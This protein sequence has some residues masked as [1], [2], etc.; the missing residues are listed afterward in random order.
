MTINFENLEKL[1]VDKKVADANIYLKNIIVNLDTL[2]YSQN[3]VLCLIKE[4]RKQNKEMHEKIEENLSKTDKSGIEFPKNQVKILDNNIDISFLINKN[5][6]D[7]IQYS[8]N[9]LDSLAQLVNCALIY[10]SKPINKVDFGYL[11]TRDINGNIRSKLGIST[12]V[13]VEKE[14][15]AIYENNIFN[16]LRK[17]NNRIKHIIDIETEISLSLLDKR[18]IENIKGFTKKNEHFDGAKLVDKCEE[19]Y[20]F[21]E[22][23]VNKV[24]MAISVDLQN[25]SIRYRYNC[26]DIKGQG[27]DLN[28]LDFLI[29][30]VKIE[31][32]ANET[33]P[34]QIE[35]MFA[36]FSK[37]DNEL[38]LFRYDYD[39]ILLEINGQFKGYA[40]LDNSSN[41]DDILNYAKYNVIEDDGAK[42][43]ELLLNHTRMR[44]YPL[45]SNIKIVKL[46]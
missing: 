15:K 23:C 16:Y 30:Y 3:L 9:I 28:N 19:I 39:Y 20:N 11:Y 21:I 26:I 40:T 42:F 10:P 6:K 22:E 8:N 24:C 36:S 7:I 46:E 32:N 45:A 37:E 29:A 1:F 31:L 17:A 34:K 14:F 4:F 27:K 5:F 25:V 44:F 43:N 12:C 18:T 2:K 33:L 41:S 35:L 38:E 13:N